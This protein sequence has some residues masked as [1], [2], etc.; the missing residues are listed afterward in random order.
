MRTF[1]GTVSLAQWAG[2]VVGSLVFATGFTLDTM[3]LHLLGIPSGFWEVLGVSVFFVAG[4]VIVLSTSRSH[5]RLKL[6]LNEA[7]AAQARRERLARI[8]AQGADILEGLNAEGN[9]FSPEQRANCETWRYGAHD[10]I[11]R[12]LPRLLAFYL[13]DDGLD[14]GTEQSKEQPSDSSNGLAIEKAA[15]FTYMSRRLQRLTQVQAQL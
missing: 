15:T 1:Q 11:A 13:S 14:L 10:F 12:E 8:I 9:G 4:G 3:G 2:V 6:R 7:L 5:H